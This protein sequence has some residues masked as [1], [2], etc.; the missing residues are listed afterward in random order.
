MHK[1][2]D[3]TAQGCVIQTGPT[4]E[5]TVETIMLEHRMIANILIV[6][7]PLVAAGV[8]MRI[9]IRSILDK[10]VGGVA[11]FLFLN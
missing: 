4:S 10:T 1:T 9:G 3:R 2:N 7:I 6:T 5:G 8:W 11:I